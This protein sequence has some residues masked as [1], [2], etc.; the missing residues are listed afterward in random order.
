MLGFEGRV[1]IITGAAKG[2]GRGY[3]NHFAAAGARV[4]IADIQGAERAAEEIIANGGEAVAAPGSIADERNA[5]ATVETALA[6]FGRLD[7]L[8]NNAGN[9]VGGL[10]HTI[11]TEEFESVL[12]VHV[13]GAFWT[14]RTAL[15]AMR[16]AGY[17]RIV[18]TTSSLGAFGLAASG[19]YVAAKAALIG[20]TKAAALEN[21]DQDIRINAIAPVAA[22]SM[23]A[24]FFDANPAVVAEGFRVEDVVPAVAYLSHA[25]CSV[26][27]QV[28]SAGAGRIGSFAHG[29]SVGIFEPGIADSE[30]AARLEAILATSELIFP[31]SALGELDL[32]TR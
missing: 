18:N 17:G 7:I 12:R 31:G 6:T 14:M 24:K 5:E 15:I 25:T 3:A 20:L 8:I 19:P 4:V 30:I 9:S 28:L 22:T 29:A 10:I 2:L 32:L 11:T 23:S 1:A 21:L 13:Y 27:G 26:T 16:Q